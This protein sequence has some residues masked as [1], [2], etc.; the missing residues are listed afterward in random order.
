M[1]PCVHVAK[2]LIA[3]FGVDLAMAIERQITLRQVLHVG[4]RLAGGGA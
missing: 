1:H 2:A 3:E 4:V